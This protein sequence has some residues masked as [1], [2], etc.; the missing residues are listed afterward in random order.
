MSDFVLVPV[1]PD[2]ISL[3]ALPDSFDLVQYAQSIN[4]Q[5]RRSIVGIVRNMTY[6]RTQQYRAKFPTIANASASGELPP[7]FDNFL[8]N[9]PALSTATYGTQEF[10]TLKQ[11][12]T[13]DYDS[14]RKVALELEQRCN[15]YQFPAKQRRSSYGQVFRRVL[16]ALAA[17]C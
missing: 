3:E 9:H 5:E 14:V 11:R 8:A 7:M 10:G 17:N 1:K 4:G 12:F 13:T 15:A 16:D 2:Q 6:R